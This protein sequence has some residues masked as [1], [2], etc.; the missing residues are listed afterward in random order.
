VSL[1]SSQHSQVSFAGLADSSR[2]L[3]LLPDPSSLPQCL[4]S[5]GT[6]PA[7]S[8]MFF[9]PQVYFFC[10]A[11]ACYPA[12]LETCSTVCSSGTTRESGMGCCLFSLV[13]GLLGHKELKTMYH[14]SWSGRRRSS[15]HHNTT[16]RPLD[17]VSSPGAVGFEDSYELQS[18]GTR[19]CG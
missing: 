18:P 10:N 8:F 9:F 7:L 16:G 13:L 14:S 1:F 6:K 4:L 15:G 5:S 11:S 17:I 12:G 2:D 19:A 3:T